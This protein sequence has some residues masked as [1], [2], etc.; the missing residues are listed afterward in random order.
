MV[1]QRPVGAIRGRL[2]RVRVIQRDV[3]SVGDPWLTGG[4]VEFRWCE[5]LGEGSL[6]ADAG[7]HGPGVVRIGCRGWQS[8][9][10]LWKT[11]SGILLR[12]KSECAAG[13][14]VFESGARET[15]DWSGQL[16]HL[17]S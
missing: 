15:I 7:R 13:D 16:S 9:A 17:F 10:G 6:R 5:V 8:F 3:L 1:F 14:L 4:R 12:E 11:P 2:Q